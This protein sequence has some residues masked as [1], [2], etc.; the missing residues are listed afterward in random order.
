MIRRGNRIPC[1]VGTRGPNRG[2]RFRTNH[3]PFPPAPYTRH[4]GKNALPVLLIQGLGGNALLWKPQMPA[5]P[6]RFRVYA[7]EVI[8]QMGKSAN[9]WLP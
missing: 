8:G 2:Y 1:G 4:G 3:S 5:L 7:E 6:G 9:T